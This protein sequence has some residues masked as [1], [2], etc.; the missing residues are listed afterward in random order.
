M[1][2]SLPDHREACTLPEPLYLQHP[3]LLCL[4]LKTTNLL[5][6]DCPHAQPHVSLLMHLSGELVSASCPK[7]GLPPASPLHQSLRLP[8]PLCWV[9]PLYVLLALGL[10]ALHLSSYTFL[11]QSPLSAHPIVYLQ[12]SNLR[13]Y[14]HI[15][16]ITVL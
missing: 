15:L 13:I 14:I 5:S 4:F 8:H 2:T 11:F 6:L 3:V 1:R 12:M 16:M 10:E 9:Q 7:H